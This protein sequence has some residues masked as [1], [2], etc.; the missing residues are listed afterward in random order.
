MLAT[1]II[2]NMVKSSSYWKNEF[3]AKRMFWGEQ[4]DD[5]QYNRFGRSDFSGIQSLISAQKMME[6]ST[7]IYKDAY[8]GLF[9][10]MKGWYFWRA[11]METGDI[12]Y[13]EAL[14]IDNFP[15]PKYD[16]QKDVFKGVLSDLAL[17][18][19]YFGKATGNFSGDPFYNGNPKKWRKATNVLRLKVLMSLQKRAEDT[20]E[21]KVK[22]TFAQI[23]QAGNLFDSNDDNLQVTYASEPQT[24]QNPYHKDYTRSIEVYAATTMLVNPM[25][26]YKDKRLFYYLAPAR[27]LTE[28]TY[29]P[30]GETLHQN[31]DYDAYVGVEVAG[32]F[33]EEKQRFQT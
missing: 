11:T 8:T 21:L 33:D 16:E 12:P 24:N 10:F 25:K 28:A 22:E 23:V 5:I 9:Y 7:D 31:N 1:G 27:A 4:M 26:E 29:L 17:A 6:L 18:D 30:Q 3:L 19:E 32:T 2:L 14:D 15:Y 13:S 20:P